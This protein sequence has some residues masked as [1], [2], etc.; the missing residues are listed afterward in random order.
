MEMLVV[1]AIF[2]FLTTIVANIYLIVSSSQ[3]YIANAQKV[4]SEARYAL[5]LI[6]REIRSKQID[7]S[8]YGRELYYKEDLLALRDDEGN[9]TFFQI[10]DTDC[11]ANSAQCLQMMKEG[12][13]TWQ[14]VTGQNI[15]VKQAVFSIWPHWDPFVVDQA[16]GIAASNDQPMV[17]ILLELENSTT[18]EK[19]KS[20]I[21]VQTSI[22]SRVYKR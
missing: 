13:M 9:Q 20:N 6:S 10:S 12:M 8:A 22:S 18:M 11:P 14:N 4:Q 15:N 21:K 19:Y 7:Y 1:L 5:E 2:S 17:T 16:T 3:K